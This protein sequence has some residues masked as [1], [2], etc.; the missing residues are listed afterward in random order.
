MTNVDLVRLAGS[1]GRLSESTGVDPVTAEVIRGGMETVCFEMANTSRARRPRRSSTS[2]TSA[3]PPCST[4]RAASPRCRSGSR[5][6]CSPL[7]CRCG[8]RSEFLGVDEFREG[9]VFVANDPYHGGGHLPDY[10][11][12]APVFADAPHRPAAGG[13]WC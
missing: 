6:S 13:G 12:F 4:R 7:R 8:S 2:R 5:S 1:R 10:N 9:D 11:V 3:T